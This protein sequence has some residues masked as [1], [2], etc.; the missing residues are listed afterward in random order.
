MSF[1]TTADEIAKHF[2]HTCGETPSVRLLTTKGDPKALEALPKSKQKSIAKGKALDPSKPRSKGC[3]FVEFTSQS[4]L[5]KALLFHHTQFGGRQINVELTAGGGGKSE[6][7]MQKIKDKNA[8][9]EKDRVS[10]T[11]RSRKRFGHRQAETFCF[12]MTQKKKHEK[13]VAPANAAHKAE[14][15][16]K[17]ARGEGG[18]PKKKVRQDGEGDAQWGPRAGQAPAS[19]PARMPRFMASGSNAVRLSQV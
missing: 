12:T 7:R 18:P 2:G 5:R 8:A 4:A 3:A 17:A 9:L 16:E 19:R 10:Y 6:K 11:A 1:T 14:Q 15:A 13:Y